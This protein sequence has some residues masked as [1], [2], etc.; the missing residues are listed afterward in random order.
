MS[1]TQQSNAYI[2]YEAARELAEMVRPAISKLIHSA[3]SLRQ[4]KTTPE[5]VQP[6]I[7]VTVER[8]VGQMQAETSS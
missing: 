8:P 5:A 4:A 6:E 7:S 2:Q 3:R 1:P